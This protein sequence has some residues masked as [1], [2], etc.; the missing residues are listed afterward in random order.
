MRGNASTFLLFVYGTLKRG[1][2]R[3]GP[4]ASQRYRGETRTRSKYALYDLGDYPGLTADSEFG[5]AVHG[6]VY[7]V[8]ATLSA[9]LDTVEGAPNWFKRDTIDVEG[10]SE[11]VWAYFYQG[12]PAGARR[13]D[14]GRWDNDRTS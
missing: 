14:S 3:H 4:L 11:P 2:C 8:E 12:D 9:W 1:G 7:E 6:E 5:Q 13:I 10:F